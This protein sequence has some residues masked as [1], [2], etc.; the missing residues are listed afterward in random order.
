MHYSCTRIPDSI[1]VVYAWENKVPNAFI[2]GAA[3]HVFLLCSNAILYFLISVMTIF[4]DPAIRQYIS[5][6]PLK[7]NPQCG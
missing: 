2:H 7:L 5:D 1:I 3:H 4:S 6:R